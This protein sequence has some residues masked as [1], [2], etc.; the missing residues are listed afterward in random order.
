MENLIEIACK[1]LSSGDVPVGAV[2]KKDENIIAISYNTREREQ[3]VLGHAEINAIFEAQ[4]KLNNWN[5][6]GCELYV[7]LKPC[8]MCLEVIKQARIDKVYY[9]LDKPS[10]KH[11]YNKTTLEKINNNDEEKKYVEILNE[12]FKKIREK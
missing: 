10:F 4:K 9:L 2:I 1:S 6:N 12:F 5:L 8:S 7:T 11:E 3:N